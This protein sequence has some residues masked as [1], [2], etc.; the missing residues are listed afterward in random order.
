MRN[1]TGSGGG[2]RGWREAEP[3]GDVEELMVVRLI[4]HFHIF[5]LVTSHMDI[6]TAAARLIHLVDA[7]TCEVTNGYIWKWLVKN[8]EN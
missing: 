4:S 8:I 3:Q 7:S 1:T 5:P 2:A 6:S